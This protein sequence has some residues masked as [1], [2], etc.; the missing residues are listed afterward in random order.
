MR[1]P[2]L[3]R[4]PGVARPGTSSERITSLLDFAPTFCEAAGLPV[5]EGTHGRSLTGLLRGWSRTLRPL[6]IGA[7]VTLVAGWAVAQYPDLLP[8]SLTIDDGAG[9][10]ATLTALIVVFIVALIV[11]V[12]ALAL[13]FRLAQRRAFE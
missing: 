5:P 2:C 11:V 4:W 6:A 8:G 12:P 3:V 13:L 1:T 10:G 7:V 9:D